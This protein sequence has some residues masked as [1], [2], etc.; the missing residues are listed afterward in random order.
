M[1]R[2][3]EASALALEIIKQLIEALAPV[4]RAKDEQEVVAAN[5]A[6]EVAAWVDALVQ[7]LRQTQQHFVTTAIAVDI[8]EGFETVDVDVANDRFTPLLQQ[9][10]QALLNW[11]IARQQGQRIG[12]TGLLDFQFGDQLEYVDDP[13]KTQV[14]TIEGDD[15]VFFNALAGAAGDQAAD[16]L[17]RLTHFHGEEVVVHQAA[18][19]FACEQVGGEWLEQGI[20][21]GVTMDDAAGLALF[22]EY[23]Q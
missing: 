17:Q 15:E 1:F 10:R 5:M 19:R 3:I 14:A 23:R 13:A 22:V 8:V 6:D 21:Q 18:D 12:V 20:R 4:V 9:P 7:T 16:L 2:A 11:H